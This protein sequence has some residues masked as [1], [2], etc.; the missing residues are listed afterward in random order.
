MLPDWDRNAR[1]LVAKFRADSTRYLGDPEFEQLIQSLRQSS[2]DFYNEWRRHNVARSGEGRK[3]V[4]HPVAG[5]LVFE[6]AVFNPAEAPEQ[7]L[8]LYSP[9]PEHDTPA[10]LAR[11]ME[12]GGATV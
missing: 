11:L 10:K 6:H 1:L 9:L 7:R 3:Q 5:R 4:N 2:P 8:I 12:D